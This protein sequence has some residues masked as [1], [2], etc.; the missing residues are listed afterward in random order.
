MNGSQMF[1][2]PNGMDRLFR[3][4]HHAIRRQKDRSDKAG[5]TINQNGTTGDAREMGGR[6]EAVKNVWLRLKQLYR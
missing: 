1:D 5:A 3:E 2:S 6:G 4:F